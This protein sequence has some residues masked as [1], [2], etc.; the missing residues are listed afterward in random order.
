MGFRH[1]HGP[2]SLSKTL[3]SQGY[4]L[5]TPPSGGNCG[6][7]VHSK[8]REGSEEPLLAQVPTACGPVVM[9]S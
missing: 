3:F 7:N 2:H 4:I 8:D 1:I 6:W 9:F 5:E